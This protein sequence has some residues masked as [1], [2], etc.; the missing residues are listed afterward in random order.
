MGTRDPRID[1]YI[2]K[3]ADFAKPILT[4]LR[5]TVH[6]AC[7]AVEEDMKWS[8]PHFMYK[9][10]LCSMAAFTQHAAFGFWKAGLVLGDAVNRDGMGHLG[11]ITTLSDL[12]ST[13][14]L[15]GYI[16][17]A[18]ALNDHG[19]SEPR[20]RRATTPKPVRVPPALA[21]A[22]KKNAKARAAFAAFAPSQQRDYAEWIA[23]AKTDATRA[24][25]LAQA[26][27]WIAAGRTRNW[28]YERK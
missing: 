4:Q 19:V 1:A 23:E 14:V 7:P 17:K 10:M 25:R 26:I 21:A 13:R 18:A 5:E 24:R 12:P 2:A 6:A 22:L 16:K 3:S 27:E 8:F 11:K 28:K 20:P 15:A 9:G